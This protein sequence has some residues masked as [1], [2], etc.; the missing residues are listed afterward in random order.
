M[1]N[2]SP[3]VPSF[4]RRQCRRCCCRRYRRCRRCRRRRRTYR[5]YRYLFLTISHPLHGILFIYFNLISSI[6]IFS[7][8]LLLYSILS[9]L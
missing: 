3:F 9:Y 5:L 7:F 2:T 6:L 8:P 1:N 4:R